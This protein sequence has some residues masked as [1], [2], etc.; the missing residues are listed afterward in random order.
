MF[1]FG[2]IIGAGDTLDRTAA[3]GVRGTVRVV[4]LMRSFMK[5]YVGGLIPVGLVLGLASGVGASGW[6]SIAL[7]N[8]SLASSSPAN[9]GV[10]GL[11]PSGPTKIDVVVSLSKTYSAK[12]SGYINFSGGSEEAC[13]FD[14]NVSTTGPVTTGKLVRDVGGNAYVEQLSGTLPKGAQYGTYYAIGGSIQPVAPPLSFAPSGMY[15]FDATQ[16]SKDGA[17]LW[18]RFRDLANFSSLANAKSGLLKLNS[19]VLG[20]ITESGDVLQYIELVNAAHFGTSKAAETALR[21]LEG[22]PVP[23]I[24]SFLTDA[25]YYLSRS[26]EVTT[27]LVA[28]KKGRVITSVRFS[29][30][31]KENVPEVSG[32][33]AADTLMKSLGGAA[34]FRSVFK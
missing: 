33:S 4:N 22:T 6:V 12:E 18:C 17:A 14:I 34:A 31:A 11:L 24:G 23:S 19:K 30:T 1:S 3:F 15:G 16:L 29:P 26:G 21:T 27:L 20:K 8:Y 2:Y 5:K 28:N 10:A 9:S 7:P 32:V 13:T 25:R